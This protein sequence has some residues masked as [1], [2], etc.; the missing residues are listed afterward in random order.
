[1]LVGVLSMRNEYWSFKTLLPLS[2]LCSNAHYIYHNL[3]LLCYTLY[4]LCIFYF[5]SDLLSSN[6]IERQISEEGK[7]VVIKVSTLGCS[8]EIKPIS[9]CYLLLL[10]LVI[11]L[12]IYCCKNAHTQDKCWKRFVR[13]MCPFII[14]LA[15]IISVLL[16][17]LTP[18]I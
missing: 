2:S 4:Q 17:C 8:F 12:K 3:H 9:A 14:C 7:S 10:A 1:M 13:E 6:Y 5:C 16:L 18:I 15:F 11:F